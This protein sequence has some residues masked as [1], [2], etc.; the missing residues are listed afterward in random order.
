MHGD[1][2]RSLEVQR[3]SIGI[4]SVPSQRPSAHPYTSLKEDQR[5]R[6]PGV[7]NIKFPRICDEMKSARDEELFHCREEGLLCRPIQHTGQSDDHRRSP[8]VDSHFQVRAP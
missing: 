3:G 1:S 5:T 4:E 2:C 8:M 6:S 7:S